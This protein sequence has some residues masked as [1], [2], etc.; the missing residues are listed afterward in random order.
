MAEPIKTNEVT[1]KP[2]EPEKTQKEQKLKEEKIKT[3]KKSIPQAIRIQ[4]WNTY[5][6]EKARTGSCMALCKKTIDITD[7]ECGHVQAEAKGGATTIENLRPICHSCNRS[8]STMNLNEWI[9]KHGLNQMDDFVMITDKLEKIE[10]K[11]EP[12]PEKIEPKIEKLEPKKCTLDCKN[13]VY[14]ADICHKHWK[15]RKCNTKRC[16]NPKITGHQHC[17]NHMIVWPV[18]DHGELCCYILGWESEKTVTQCKEVKK[19]G[20]FCEAHMKITMSCYNSP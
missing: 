7:F 6:G 2:N 12:K 8:M 11:L 16:K 3:K 14:K 20:P 18:I 5:I 1:K 13:I 17:K 19:I 9:A 15:I 4:V 10:P